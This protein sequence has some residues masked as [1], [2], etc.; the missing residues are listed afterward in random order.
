MPNDDQLKN[1]NDFPAI[2]FIDDEEKILTAISRALKSHPFQVFV[3][4]NWNEAEPILLDNSIA[5]AVCDRNLK[6]DCGIQLLEKLSSQFPDIVR[7]MLSGDTKSETILSSINRGHVYR[8]I[9]K[10]W[11]LIGLIAAIDDAVALHLLFNERK[12]FEKDLIAVNVSL[13]EKV[14]KSTQAMSLLYTELEQSFDATIGALLSILALH[15]NLSV[16][17]VKRTAVRVSDLCRVLDVSKKD[18]RIAQRAALLHLTGLTSVAPS[19]FETHLWEIPLSEKPV[20]EFHALLGQQALLPVPALKVESTVI[21]H[22]LHPH[23]APRRIQFLCQILAAS[24]FFEH[25]S[26]VVRR[27]RTKIEKREI[28]ALHERFAEEY[29]F[30][31]SVVLEALFTSEKRKARDRVESTCELDALR[32]GMILSRAVSTVQGVALVPAEMV[33][34]GDLIETLKEYGEELSSVFIWDDKL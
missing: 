10:P 8:F 24:S 18:E 11:D 4:L 34:D 25:A 22:Y 20:W 7:I 2:L 23:K 15:S 6:G 9:S 29:P 19:F 32:K 5:V 27:G 3:A 16:S 17:H 13:E 26:Y 30:L 28:A 31:D 33:V 14:L 12:A 1:D 21:A